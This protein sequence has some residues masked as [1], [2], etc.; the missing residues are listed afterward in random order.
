MH[1][2]RLEKTID[3][4]LILNTEDTIVY[5][6]IYVKRQNRLSSKEVDE[7]I[8]KF[9]QWIH[10]YLN[11]SVDTASNFP[12]NFDTVEW[13]LNWY[14]FITTL[15]KIPVIDIEVQKQANILSKRQNSS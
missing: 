4:I 15:I 9:T 10:A 11:V 14:S 5:R 1:W 2:L 13:G 6:I 8:Q 3:S 7:R 12:I